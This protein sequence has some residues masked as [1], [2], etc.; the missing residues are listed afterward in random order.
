MPG[1][2]LA[3]LGLPPP[4]H[5][6]RLAADEGARKLPSLLPAPCVLSSMPWAPQAAQENLAL[7]AEVSCLQTKVATLQASLQATSAGA[8]DEIVRANQL[9][10]EREQQLEALRRDNAEVSGELDKLRAT[11]HTPEE[12]QAEVAK[13]DAARVAL[14][15]S[16]RRRTQGGRVRGMP[17]ADSPLLT[18]RQR[19]RRRSGRPTRSLPQNPRSRSATSSS[20]RRSPRG[21]GFSTRS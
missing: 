14:K 1:A 6:R 7:R 4:L 12:F 20:R 2:A 3:G 17:R 9:L 5:P 19:R 18:P 13:L 8:D 16:D 21:Q 15:A 10:S 11:W